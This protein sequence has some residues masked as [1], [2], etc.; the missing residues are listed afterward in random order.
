MWDA[1]YEHDNAW[2]KAIPNMIAKFREGVSPAQE[3]REKQ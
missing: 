2:R 1:R 3:A